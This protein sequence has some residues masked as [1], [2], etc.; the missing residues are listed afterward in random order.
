MPGS[1]PGGLAST[2]WS[3]A[4]LLLAQ[5]PLKDRENNRQ[6]KVQIKRLGDRSRFLWG[7]RSF[8]RENRER[9][10]VALSMPGSATRFGVFGGRVRAGSSSSLGVWP[11][12]NGILRFQSRDSVE[13]LAFVC[14]LTTGIRRGSWSK[15]GE[16]RRS[17]LM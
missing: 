9:V 12:C 8:F 11:F 5:R 16:R 7:L 15:N 3:A 4:C 14:L 2:A 6:D 1:F 10:E 17:R 13:L